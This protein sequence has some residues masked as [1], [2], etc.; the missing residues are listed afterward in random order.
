[1]ISCREKMDWTEGPRRK[2]R[3]EDGDFGAMGSG[4]KKW[5]VG[6]F[7]WKRVSQSFV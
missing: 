4:K 2:G 5:E 7:W 3:E 6:E 1:M